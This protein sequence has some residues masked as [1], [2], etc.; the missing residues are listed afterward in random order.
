MRLPII[1]KPSRCWYG[2]QVVSIV[3][4]L[5]RGGGSLEIDPMKSLTDSA[6][7]ATSISTPSDWFRTQPF[8]PQRLANWKI[9]G[10]K[11]TPCTM[12]R[13]FTRTRRPVSP[14]AA[15]SGWRRRV[16]SVEDFTISVCPP[17]VFGACPPS[18]RSRTARERNL[19]RSCMRVQKSCPRGSIA[20][21][22]PESL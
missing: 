1:L 9:K 6:G 21:P 14:P 18:P 17:G 22:F 12:P 8:S 16:S 13:T 3:T 4:I 10:R 20:P 7:P 2:R 5:A 19:L 11:P 15:D